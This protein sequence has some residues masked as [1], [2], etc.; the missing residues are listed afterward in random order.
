MSWTQITWYEAIIIVLTLVLLATSLLPLTR[1]PGWW[2]RVWDFPRLQQT[3]AGLLLIIATTAIFPVNAAATHLLLLIQTLCT[4]YQF[5]WIFPYTPFARKEVAGAQSA[6]R[7]H[8]QRQELGILAANV[9]QTNRAADK[10]IQQI[11]THQPDLVIALETDAWWMQQ[12]D[13]LCDSPQDEVAYP[14]VLRCPLDNLY[15]M[16]VYSRWPIVDS[17]IKYLVEDGVPSMHFS[18]QLP[19]GD[20]VKMHCLHPAPPSPTE[21]DESTERDAEL[22][23]V[24]RQVAQD[25][26]REPQPVIVTGDL[27]D[28]AWSRTTRLFRKLSGLLDPR[29]GRGLYNTFHA[30]IP[31]LRWPLDHLFHSDHFTLQDIQRLDAIGSDHFPIL[32]RLVLLQHRTTQENHVE[33]T[34][35]DREHADEVVERAKA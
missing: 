4:L 8:H 3:A 5:W 2:F 30:Q 24:A 29:I 21:N 33:V 11:H 27:N 15:G 19:Q 17:E 6:A 28:V 26:Q 14:H 16:L 22:V 25:M 20:K 1:H 9:L 18:L 32:A 12:L 31:F 7:D 10:L 34:H 13:V 23:I 35:E